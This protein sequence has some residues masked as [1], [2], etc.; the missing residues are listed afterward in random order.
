MNRFARPL[1]L[2]LL[3]CS[4]A[5]QQNFAMTHTKA[6]PRIT[7]FNTV[8]T[9]FV[10][11]AL[12]GNPAAAAT[13]CLEV[14]A[15]DPVGAQLK[16]NDI[17]YNERYEK[18]TDPSSN[19]KRLEGVLEAANDGGPI[20]VKIA[21]RIDCPLVEVADENGIQLS[22]KCRR[23]TKLNKQDIQKA[24]SPAQKQLA[25]GKK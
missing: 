15:V 5:V 20:D 12:L 16:F 11:L 23:A 25:I 10:A 17:C 1:A 8:K 9:A 2:T 22:G 19:G 24:A 3:L 14:E 4:A 21:K 13:Q 6:M 7:L 18:L